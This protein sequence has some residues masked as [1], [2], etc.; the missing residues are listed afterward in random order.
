MKLTEAIINE[1]L[2]LA[3]S[4]YSVLR[5]MSLALVYLKL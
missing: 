2:M 1:S 4:L 5:Q 3:T